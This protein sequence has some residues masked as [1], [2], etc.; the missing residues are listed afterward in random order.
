MDG[1]AWFVFE[2]RR[3]NDLAFGSQTGKWMKYHVVKTIC[4]SRIDFENFATDLLAD[5]QFIEDNISLCVEKGDC[6]LVTDRQ[7]TSELLIIPWHG[8]FVRYAALRPKIFLV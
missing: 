8:C 5:R 2:P 6:L 3:I 4:L 1:K 7:R